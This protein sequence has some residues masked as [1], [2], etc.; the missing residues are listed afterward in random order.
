MVD[1]SI[2]N[3]TFS[4]S[5]RLNALSNFNISLNTKIRMDVGFIPLPSNIFTIESFIGFK[6]TCNLLHIIETTFLLYVYIPHKGYYT[7]PKIIISVH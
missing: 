7:L 3:N 2:L 4:K 1:L 6:I 5:P